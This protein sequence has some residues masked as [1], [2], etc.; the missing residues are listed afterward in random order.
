MIKRDK[1][2]KFR[3]RT[4]KFFLTYPRLPKREDL[5]E[6]ALL[7]YERTFKLQRSNFHYLISEELH[8]DGN[9]HL[10]VY[11]EFDK[12]QKIYSE[13]KLDLVIDKKNYHGNYQSVKFKHSTIE[14]IIK[15]TTDGKEYKTNMNLPVIGEKYYDNIYDHLH[16]VV[17]TSGFSTGVDVLYQQYP[18]E[19]IQRGS[20]LL[21]N[22]E[23]ASSY[24]Y[25]IEDQTP[26]HRLE[27]FVDVPQPLL[28]W[29]EKDTPPSVLISGESNVGK[30]ALAKALMFKRNTRY[31]FVRHIEGIKD[32][33]PDFHTGIIFDDINIAT[34]DKSQMINL[35]DVEDVQHLRIL[36]KCSQVRP[37]TCK[38]F[39]TNN[40][41]PYIN[42]GDKALTRR[43]LHVSIEKTMIPNSLDGDTILVPNSPND[44][45]GILGTTKTED[46]NR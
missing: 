6:I 41:S 8:K 45:A 22:M 35:F 16:A 10:H 38:I 39:T 13:G 20:S 43:L 11:L 4:K 7:H 28:D 15:S 19:S 17:M 31:L 12:V 2:N 30:T 3:I 27:D 34:M 46:S 33:R 32:Y 23:L 26:R 24:K 18:R 25:S 21:K 5:I 29:I 9:P 42:H 1:P 36:F 44:P 40:P 37:H 14:Y